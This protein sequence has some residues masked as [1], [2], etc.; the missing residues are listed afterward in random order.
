MADCDFSHV[1]L[2]YLIQARDLARQNPR[3]SALLLD[4][5]ETLAC[6]LAGVTPAGLAQITEFKPPL[7]SP[8]LEEWWWER[9]LLA[10]TEGAP[11]ELQVILEHAG[12][13]ADGLTGPSSQR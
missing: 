12:M 2:E 13:L 3:A 10:L 1:N 5:P 11:G 8:R 6:R 9:L 4:I 7:V